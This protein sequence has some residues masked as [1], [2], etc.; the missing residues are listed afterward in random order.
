[1]APLSSILASIKFNTRVKG[2]EHCT[3]QV[4]N[5]AALLTE[6]RRGIF[7]L[8]WTLPIGA[9]KEKKKDKRHP[10]SHVFFTGKIVSLT[11]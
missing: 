4:Y 10:L 6:R 2:E 3:S 5:T 1:M 9:K 11:E 7:Q 8:V